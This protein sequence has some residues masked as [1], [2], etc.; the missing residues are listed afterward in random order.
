MIKNLKKLRAEKGISQQQLADIIGVSQQSV[1]KYENHNSEPEIA[2][3]I[4]I[5]NY[6]HTSVDY[7]IGHTEIN[8]VIETLHPYDLN[9]EEIKLIEQ[10]RELSNKERKSINLVIENYRLN[11]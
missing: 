8:H 9:K 11:K 10:Y 3:L 2:V 1:N 4:N 7:L 6:F 5:A